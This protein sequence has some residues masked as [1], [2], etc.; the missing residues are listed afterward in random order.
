M[1][2]DSL[3]ECDLVMKGGITSGIVYPKAALRLKD[4][5]RFRNVGGASAGAIA[6]GVVAAAE[7]GR[8]K[9]GF[10]RIAKVPAEMS[11]HL[12]DLFQPWPELRALYSVFV[13]LTNKGGV[14]GTVVALLAGYWPW[15][16][17]GLVIATL[18]VWAAQAS[19]A[20]LWLVVL[21]GVAA[22]LL[23]VTILV[24]VGV[25]FD[26]FVKLP[27][28]DF[29]LCPGSAKGRTPAYPPL[30]DWL[31]TLIEEAAGRSVPPPGGKPLTFEDLAAAERP[32]K[33]RMMT[34]NLSLGRAHA[35][36]G[37]DGNHYWKEDEFRELLPGWV[38]DY[39]VKTCLPDKDFPDLR[40]FPS[41][42][43]VVLGIR[44][45]LSF[46]ILIS[47]VPVY[48]KDHPTGDANTLPEIQ[49]MLFSDGGISSNFPVH[50]F[51]SLFP[52]RPTFGISLEK[53]DPRYKERRVYLPMP[54]RRGRWYRMGDQGTLGRFLSAILNTAR[55]WQ[56]R[57]RTGESGFRERV[58]HVY[59]T[60]NEGGLNLEM[61][62]T[63]I[64]EL[65]SLGDRAG[66]LMTGEPTPGDEFPFDFNDHRWRRFLVAYG[67]IEELLEEV[68]PKWGT[69]ADP[70]SFA[71]A[72][73]ATLDAPPSYAG[74]KL[75]SRKEAFRRID[76]LM[77]CAR[78][79]FS[80]R[81]REENDLIP[82][83]NSR[84]RIVPEP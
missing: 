70:K 9:G 59:L 1:A 65:V 67:A 55:E 38:V 33:L 57:L 83:H 54:A 18:F 15:A 63:T 10:E 2:D 22:L 26:V 42:M 68:A 45:S 19:G 74:S 79:E 35:L 64:D 28:R 71:S 7:L 82:V 14:A 66:G 46:P 58:V 51:D 17:A 80:K 24:A 34:T 39:L 49:R 20:A 50:F 43:P 81:L 30:S 69:T 3:L 21:V 4:K 72:I 29:G 53:F 16:L 44:M 23:G 84:L 48:R 52:G 41:D 62:K 27:K 8:A 75:G 37:L 11:A 40:P 6:A 5:Y 36:P 60:E 25:L 77:Q 73:A 56:D 61:E 78:T 76:V 32:I 12:K 31:A 47:A 13:A